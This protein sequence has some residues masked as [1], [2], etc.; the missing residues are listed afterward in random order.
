MKLKFNPGE[1]LIIE[2][3]NGDVLKCQ[4]VSGTD[5]HIV[6][7]DISEQH[8]G[9]KIPG[10]LTYYRSELVDVMILE[11][12]NRSKEE[13]EE[14]EQTEEPKEQKYV[15][16]CRDKFE[17]LQALS[18][19][20]LFLPNI[21]SRYY[22]AVE[23]LKKCESIGVAVLCSNFGRTSGM[24]LLVLSSRSQVYIF[25]M[26]QYVK[27]PP[28]LKAIFEC[29][30]ILKIAHGAA[31]VADCLRHFYRVEFIN[32]FDTQLADF[33]VLSGNGE[34]A[35]LRNISECLVHHFRFPPSLLEKSLVILTLLYS[36]NEKFSCYH[37]L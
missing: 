10:T 5:S 35:A 30:D 24:K 19:E 11:G 27:M 3:N 23:Y 20:H 2:L 14:E 33:L 36:P 1:Q 8:S 37:T 12:L 22:E 4:Y 16:L 34:P 17:K 28:E 9:V 25:D 6:V 31:S 15:L 18:L 7:R 13:V 32:Y 29:G 21:D 26:S